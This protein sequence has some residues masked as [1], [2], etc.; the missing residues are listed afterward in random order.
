MAT[1]SQIAGLD[2]AV[3]TLNFDTMFSLI[4]AALKLVLE[5]TILRTL[6][7]CGFLT[8]SDGSEDHLL[9][10]SKIHDFSDGLRLFAYARAGFNPANIADAG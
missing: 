5:E 9:Y 6:Q 7:C 1:A 8:V 10:C 2:E 4:S 3:P